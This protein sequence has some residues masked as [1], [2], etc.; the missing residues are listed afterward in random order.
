M[1]DLS[2]ISVE[3]LKPRELD[4]LI[5]EHIMGTRLFD[6]PVDVVMRWQAIIH[7]DGPRPTDMQMNRLLVPPYST[8]IALAWRV[9]EH[10][11]A[12]GW[13][14]AVLCDEGF[15][16]RPY[17]CRIG[18]EHSAVGATAQEAIC[19]AALKAATAR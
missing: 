9:V 13:A 16:P 1:A 18:Q 4:I 19:R 10:L 8:D 17:E 7:P 14:V 2:R 15:P 3:A 6:A 11:V 5:E 12:Q